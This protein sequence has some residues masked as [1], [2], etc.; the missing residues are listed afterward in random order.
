MIGTAKLPKVLRVTRMPTA[1][2]FSNRQKLATLNLKESV[3]KQESSESEA[4]KGIAKYF[5][6]YSN[7]DVFIMTNQD[8]RDPTDNTWH[9]RDIFVINLSRGYILNLE[10]KS[11]LEDIKSWKT[12]GKP[13]HVQL[14]KT[15]EML[16]NLFENPLI[17]QQEW[18]VINLVYAPNI[19][20]N[21]NICNTVKEFII[22][23]N[24]N[25]DSKL[26]LIL[27]IHTSPVN[28]YS[29]V[30]DFYAMVSELLLERVR[31]VWPNHD[32]MWPTLF[33]QFIGG[34]SNPEFKKKIS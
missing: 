29:Y 27:D 22:T 21:F 14:Q 1:V 20:S 8:L 34:L 10:V 28:S 23:E 9:E 18:K 32:A 17:L 15:T 16:T 2:D 6:L 25:F 12:S 5:D 33:R 24:D 26:T 13:A 3:L 4:I 19:D 11:V 7:E 30:K 31:L